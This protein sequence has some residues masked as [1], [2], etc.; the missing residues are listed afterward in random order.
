MSTSQEPNVP[1]VTPEAVVEQLRALRVQINDE[2]SP[3]TKAQRRA[4]IDRGKRQT[5]TILQSTISIIGAAD[6]VSQAV[7]LPA[8]EVRQMCDDSNRWVAVADELRALLNGV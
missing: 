4:F 7:G 6:L 1:K 5:N 8:A 3:L 2:L